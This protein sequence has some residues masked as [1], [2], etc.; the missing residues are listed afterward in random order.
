MKMSDLRNKTP[1]Q[2]TKQVAK[3]QEDIAINHREKKNSKDTNVRAKNNMRKQIAK[4]KT[5]IREFELDKQNVEED[6]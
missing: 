6:K 4:L 5:V 2:L 3:L 1:D